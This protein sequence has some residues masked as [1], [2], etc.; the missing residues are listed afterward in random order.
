MNYAVSLA[1][2]TSGK[3][4]ISTSFDSYQK[5]DLELGKTCEF[6]GISPLDTSKYILHARKAL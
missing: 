2:K 5:C 1:S 4:K 6:R 3:G